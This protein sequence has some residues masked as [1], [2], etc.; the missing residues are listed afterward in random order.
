MLDVTAPDSTRV[1]VRTAEPRDVAGLLDAYEWLFAA[2][3]T[4]PDDWDV[5]AAGARLL[6]V[7]TI[8]QCTV[9]V[10]ER[11]QDL[12]GFCTAYLDIISVR[13]GRRCWL[14][15][16]AVHPAH[17]STGI[18]ALLLGQAKVWAARRRADHME[19]DSALAR[20]DAHRFYDRHDPSWHSLCFGWRLSRADTVGGAVQPAAARTAAPAGNG[21]QS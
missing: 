8:E 20:T 21:E 12:V 11:G 15:D 19:L 6:E 4:R 1:S 17:R 2:P 14:E 9:L 7:M 13:F 10:A 5:Q 16:L 18:G 3:G